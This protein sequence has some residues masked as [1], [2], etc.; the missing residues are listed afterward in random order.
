[1]STQITRALLAALLCA[2][3]SAQSSRVVA[4]P[5]TQNYSSDYPQIFN[6]QTQW[7]A[8]RFVP[9][10][11]AFVT[12]LG[13]VVNDAAT[14]SQWT[15]AK[16]A[17]STLDGAGVPYGICPGNHDFRYPG[18]FFD[19]LGTSYRANFGPQIFQGEA[20][21]RG[22]S[23]S[24]L[25]SYQVIEVD[26]TE[27]LFL[28]LSVET[29]AAELAWA[30]TVLNAHRN[31]PTWV[32][33]HRYLF[34]WGP[35]GAGRYDEFNYFFEPPYVPEGIPADAFFNGF[36]AAN[37]QI[38]LVHCGHNDGEHR[39]LST[40]AFGLPVHEILADYQT[41]F[42][43]GGNGW[44][45]TMDFDI[46]GGTITVQTYSPFL[47]DFRT[48]SDS[49]F[50][51]DVDFDAYRASSN[52]L[53]FQEGVTGYSGTQDTWISDEDRN[54][55][56]GSSGVIVVDDD[57]NNSIFS[58]R[59]G[60]GLLRFDGIT[61]G[62]VLEGEPDPSQV[63]LGAKIERATL[64]LNLAGDT[65]LFDPGFDVYR[66][67]RAWS[68][69]STWNDL[70]GG[71]NPGTDTIGGVL[72]RFQ[73]DNDPDLDFSRSVDVTPA[74]AAWAA[75][76]PVHGFAILPEVVSFN[77]DGIEIRSSEDGQS[78]LRPSLEVVFTY[79]P[80]NV[81]PTVT[82]SL[83]V[84]RGVVRQGDEVLLTFAATDPSPLDPLTFR[85]DG[86]DVAFATGSGEAR[87]RVLMD[88]AGTFTFTAQ[89]SD[90]EATVAAG[91]VTVEV[92]QRETVGSSPSG[93]I[94]GTI[95]R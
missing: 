61:R 36:V 34:K 40:N 90:D 29:P 53:K 93:P 43:N 7:V 24:E 47:D 63:P 88:T 95:Q 16:S 19:P 66:M 86:Q 55:S 76:E 15:T 62:Q 35:L 26:G 18:T 69:S 39:Q 21:Y 45:R 59:Q 50:V 80:V 6:S 4:L 82:A 8:S 84:D 37:R 89:V 91:S 23:P 68:E 94:L 87:H 57:V 54:T 92:L 32:S 72:G 44:L 31:L 41:T 2:T 60:Q 78:A 71:I 56:Y 81:A 48:G 85:V 10:G 3:A 13:D 65:N 12:H 58:D 5:D 73:G 67:S 79:E 46:G 42:G 14:L 83:A 28:H 30:Q 11:I 75:G 38:F 77:D 51:L 49:Q 25:S 22:S 27:L 20:W 74:M 64:R 17:M 1:M 33:T 70:G 9:D 52:F